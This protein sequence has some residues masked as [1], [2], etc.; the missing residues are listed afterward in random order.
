MDARRSSACPRAARARS[1]PARRWPTSARSPPRATPCSTGQDWDVEADGLFGAPPITVVIGEEAHPDADQGARAR[2]ASGATGSCA[3]P[4]DGQGRMRAEALPPLLAGRRS[5]ARR[6]AT[7]TPARSTRSRRS[8]ERTR[9]AGAW[10][11]VDGAF[12]LWAAA[13]A[14]RAHLAAGVELADS[15]AT[16]AHKWLNVPYDSGLAFVRDAGGAAR[17][18]GGDAPSTCR[19]PAASATRPTTRPSCRAAR[20]AS[21]SGRRCARSAARA[22]T[23]SS[24]AAAATRTRFAEGLAAA[25][26]EILNDVVLNQV[27]VSFGEPDATRA[28]DRRRCRPRARAG[29]AARS[30]RAAPRCAS[31]SRSWAT[32]ED[33]VERSLA[34]MLRVAARRLSRT[35]PSRL[36]SA[37]AARSTTASLPG[38][39]DDLQAQRQAVAVDARRAARARASRAR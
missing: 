35:Q 32:T 39:A 8:R 24:S 9:E 19:P 2:R 11:H 18:D 22:S 14:A 23:S 10:L 27:L 4:V 38:Q 21:T 36:S 16:D 25:G 26:Y 5:S 17:R 1:S 20:A 7:S 29:A 34:A 33:D 12:G 30:G 31:A 28:R 3:C 37:A 15:W 6:P 13:A